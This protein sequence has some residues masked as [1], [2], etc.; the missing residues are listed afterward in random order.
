MVA[1]SI[2]TVAGEG[3]RKWSK[4]PVK[5]NTYCFF[6]T[7]DCFFRRKE[8]EG[9][10]SRRKQEGKGREGTKN[11]RE[12]CCFNFIKIKKRLN[13]VEQLEYTNHL[14]NNVYLSSGITTHARAHTHKYATSRRTAL[15]SQ[16]TVTFFSEMECWEVINAGAELELSSVTPCLSCI[17]QRFLPH[18][19]T[20]SVFSYS[21][22]LF[23]D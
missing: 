11:E 4:R 14:Y 9:K 7:F 13:T 5:T 22:L 18:I 12:K 16:W 8:R 20:L 3:Q 10:T 6:F 15:L 19:M 23:N 1:N 17:P 21:I 2:Y